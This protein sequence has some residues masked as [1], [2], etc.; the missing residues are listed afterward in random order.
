MA[1]AGLVLAVLGLADPAPA[2]EVARAVLA[3]GY[4]TELP[5]KPPPPS[6]APAPAPSGT[7]RTERRDG[8]SPSLPS[9][10]T[11]GGGAGVLRFLALAVLVA[12]GLL[13]LV[14]VVREVRTRSALHRARSGGPSPAPSPSAPAPG[15]APSAPAAPWT[16]LAGE[17]RYADAVHALLLAALRA[18]S[19]AR[20]AAPRPSATSR[21]ILAESGLPGEVAGAL[22]DLVLAVERS[23]FGGQPVT[24]EDYG[25]ACDA[26]ARIDSVL[27]G[28]GG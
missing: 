23:R 15:A 10:S 17:G 4:Q 19:G 22:R 21:E 18:L 7:G 26:R 2:G 6:A 3:E 8:G 11:G 14:A 12:A 20:G 27:A 16:A 28:A 24:G 25:R 13:L 1:L 5:G 9:P